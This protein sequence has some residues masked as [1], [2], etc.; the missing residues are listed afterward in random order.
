MYL[1]KL[2]MINISVIKTQKIQIYLTWMIS[3]SHNISTQE[4]F[5]SNKIST[6]THRSVSTTAIGRSY[7][8]ML[9]HSVNI[10]SRMA[11][12]SAALTNSEAWIMFPAWFKADCPKTSSTV[13]T[14]YSQYHTLKELRN[15]SE[16][17]SSKLSN[18]ILH[19]S[20]N[21]IMIMVLKTTGS[22]RNSICS[23]LLMFPG[24]I[25]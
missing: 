8:W 17:Y 16:K 18:G 21:L 6:G 10:K 3:N 13:F 4:N 23:P 15:P 7:F 20:G 24:N 9:I 14:A 11:L 22:K 12:T 5:K 19:L 2:F 1:I 25:I